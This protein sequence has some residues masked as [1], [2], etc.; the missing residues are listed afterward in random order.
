[1]ASGLCLSS[2]NCLRQTCPSQQRLYKAAWTASNKRGWNKHFLFRPWTQGEALSAWLM[3][4]LATSSGFSPVVSL[5]I[6]SASA[7]HI[8][9][10]CSCTIHRPTSQAESH[11]EPPAQAFLTQL[12]W[13]TLNE[14]ECTSSCAGQR[15]QHC[16]P[17]FVEPELKQVVF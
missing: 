13:H 5:A 6:R 8:K 2:G 4:R 14:A 12:L 17:D 1:M 10:S 16:C 15:T 11:S 3:T 7:G 9:A